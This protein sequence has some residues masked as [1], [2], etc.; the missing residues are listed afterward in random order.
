VFHELS[1]SSPRDRLMGSSW[2]G[3]IMKP[4]EA[5]ITSALN[6]WKSAIERADK[7]FF[8]L[9]AEQLQK[10]VAPGKNRLIYLWGH[11]TAVHDRMLPLLSLGDRLHPEFDELFL[12]SPDK[13]VAGLPAAEAIKKSWDEVNGKLHAG[14][15][16]FSA[17]EWLHK[18]ASVS[19]EDFARDPSRN[20]FAIL[21]SR[22]SH[23]AFHL[24]QTAL[25]SK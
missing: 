10:E 12:S 4:E 6:S 19:E 13:A 9:T 3:I 11:L 25:V 21:L 22:T 8:P 20:R 23:I 24:G 7:L 2:K 16:R 17:V 18:H 15:E 1:L 14:F 5:L